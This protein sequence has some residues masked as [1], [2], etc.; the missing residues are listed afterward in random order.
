MDN[1]KRH[2]SLQIFALLTILCCLFPSCS[3]WESEL[4]EI[5]EAAQNGDRLSQ[6]AI[7]EEHQSFKDIVPE[8][9]M[10]EYLEVFINE[11]NSR[12][13]SLAAIMELK[14]YDSSRMGDYEKYSQKVLFKWYEVGIRHNDHESYKALGD[15]YMY[16]YDQTGHLQ[17]SLKADVLYQK[18]IEAGNMYLRMER[19]I[20]KGL[21]AIITSGIDYGKYS[22]ENTFDDKDPISRLVSSCAY[23]FAYISNG[24]TKLIFT[25]AWWKV[26]LTLSGMLL[27]LIV[28]IVAVKGL[29][30][31]G[32][33]PGKEGEGVPICGMIFGFWNSMCFFTAVAKQ[34][35]VWLNNTTSL[36]FHPSAYGLQQYLS[37]VMNWIALIYLIAVI[38]ITIKNNSGRESLVLTM[39]RII[40][41]CIIFIVS[42]LT[43]KIGGFLIMVVVLGLAG[44]YFAAGVVVSAPA[45]LASDGESDSASDN[46]GSDRRPYEGNFCS[47]CYHWNSSTHSCRRDP[48][49]EVTTNEYNSCNRWI[50]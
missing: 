38:L 7:I 47:T 18:S 36:I 13:I 9:T 43:A 20:K 1:F 34:N 40:T 37:I 15:H 14:K 50:P 42:Y 48:A 31:I 45:A 29:L 35:I 10:Q 8:D 22:Y 41:H 19:D 26:L 23:T 24:A 27:L 25:K 3:P 28:P 39:R 49:H 4:D 46:K 44:M 6:F 2:H 33:H 11:G 12:A 21:K 30:S 5:Y 16:K 17:D 32:L